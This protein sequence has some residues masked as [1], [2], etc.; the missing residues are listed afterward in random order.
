MPDSLTS[1][2]CLWW[3]FMTELID[4]HMHQNKNN[5][6]EN[7]VGCWPLICHV[8]SGGKAWWHYSC[9]WLVTY[10]VNNRKHGVR[11]TARR[12]RVRP[13]TAILIQSWNFHLYILHVWKYIF[14]LP[15]Y[16][17]SQRILFW[18]YFY[19]QLKFSW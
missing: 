2:H 9:K 8:T 3:P 10:T 5:W 4:S 1:A 19:Q 15:K 14:L 7:A 12:G 11:F 18:L 13:Y 6:N 17:S 16:M